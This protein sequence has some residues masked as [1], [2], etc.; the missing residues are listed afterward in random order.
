[1][2]LFGI[3][4]S[5]TI[6]SI[7]SGLVLGCAATLLVIFSLSQAT[8]PG[9]SPS[10][11][12]N[13]PAFKG[14]SNS[15]SKNIPLRTLGDLQQ[16]RTDFEKKAA[17]Y[18][19]LHNA[20]EKR[21][22]E[23]LVESRELEPERDRHETQRAIFQKLASLNPQTALDQV[24]QVPIDRQEDLMSS[25]YEE[26]SLANLDEAVKHAHDL[27]P[28]LKKAALL[29]ILRSRHDLSHGMLQ[30]IAKQ[31][32]HERLA[33]DFLGESAA[34]AALENPESAWNRLVQDSQ[35]DLAQTE[36]LI[37][38]AGEW[39]TQSGISVIDHI[40]ES[41]SDEVVRDAVVASV[42]HVVAA[43]NPHAAL[44]EAVNL[45]GS[46]RELAL[47][48][49][50]EVWAARDPQVALA[51]IA[52]IES[53][54][55]LR[56]LQETM[57]KT[58]A[59]H[60]PYEL[61]DSLELLPEN[62]RTL[63]KEAAM[64]AIA[65]TSPPAAI[66]FLAELED[67]DLRDKLAKEIATHWSE[68][69][70]HAALNWALED[71]FSTDVQQ[72]EVLMIV[73]AKLTLADPDLAFRT[74]RDQPVVLRGQYYRGMEVTVLQHL[75]E[76]DI[77]KA[78]AMLPEIR[79]EGL[80]LTH[81]Y[82]EVGRALMRDGQ[83]DRALKLGEQLDERRRRNYNGSVMYQWAL[84]EPE[85]LVESLEGLPSDQLKEQAAKGLMRFNSETK[86][87]DDEQMGYVMGFVS[88]EYIAHQNQMKS[89]MSRSRL[90]NRVGAGSLDT[91]A[92]VIFL[93]IGDGPTNESD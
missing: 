20:T 68:L 74:A 29:G 42:L 1:M 50:A 46:S 56:Q 48:T 82:S 54:N 22:L 52:S 79:S 25:I 14:K 18:Q 81:A 45:K 40:S 5:T 72:A 4:A 88:E 78:L 21:L 75:V 23:I 35:P 71:H 3:R 27:T 93:N 44:L 87:L 83:F 67:R 85:A 89:L 43:K 11:T 84:A 55:T 77:D 64:L 30:G 86:A 92:Q 15:F 32:Q 17:L 41:L 16:F 90:W 36:V 80:T 91:Q 19:F 9:G 63:A 49:I 37:R 66:A 58:W 59:T 65:Q 47:R 53:G 61:L 69:D 38:I 24:D 70:P 26:W 13:H 39:L 60:D 28:D 33:S 7:A 2:V 62:L 76:T 51:N 34:F 57:L 12:S 6:T 73:L 31:L 8:E 10:H